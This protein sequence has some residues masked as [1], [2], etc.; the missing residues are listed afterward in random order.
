MSIPRENNLYYIQSTPTQYAVN[1]FNPYH[2]MFYMAIKIEFPV[3]PALSKPLEEQPDF[4]LDDMYAFVPAFYEHLN[5]G[6]NSRLYGTFMAFKD[7]AIRIVKFEAIGDGGVWK[8][9]VALYIAYEMA[10]VISDLKDEANITSFNGEAYEKNYYIKNIEN[11]DDNVFNQNHYGFRFWN[12]YKH[13]AKLN[14]IGT[15]NSRR[16]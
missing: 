13:Y 12:R 4:T 9:L 10:L 14:V 11:W 8:Q 15:R 2:P 1:L 6:V 5:K 3:L 16:V 7:I